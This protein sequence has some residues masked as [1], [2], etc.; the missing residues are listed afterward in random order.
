MSKHSAEEWERATET[1]FA[2]VGADRMVLGL[3]CIPTP[4]YGDLDKIRELLNQ[5]DEL[6]QELADL[7]EKYDTAVILIKGAV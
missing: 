5:I 7:R 4:V 3:S 1:A 2:R 6:K